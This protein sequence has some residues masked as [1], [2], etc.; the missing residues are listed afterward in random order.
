MKKMIYAAALAISLSGCAS[1]PTA[2]PVERTVQV[3][4]SKDV[5]WDNLIEFFASKN[6]SIKTIEKDSGIVYAERT[7][8]SAGGLSEWTDCGSSGLDTP[9]RQGLDLNVFVR[10]IGTASDPKTSVTVNA[11]F[12]EMRRNFWDDSIGS[13]DCS[14]RGVLEQ[15]IQQQAAH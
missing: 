9:V 5:V 10:E 11:R 1:L 6:I 8:S 12:T 15:L 2:G 14:S 4:K 13:F 7:T 3:T